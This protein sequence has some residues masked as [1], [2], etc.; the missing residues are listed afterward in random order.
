[1]CCA[2]GRSWCRQSA[3]VYVRGWNRSSACYGQ[4][5]VRDRGRYFSIRSVINAQL[6]LFVV[7]KYCGWGRVVSIA[8]ERLLLIN[9]VEGI[10]ICGDLFW[11]AL[12]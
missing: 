8:K 2:C 4:F 3:Q 11:I 9:V 5:Y 12:N 10:L 7:G 6:V 1:M